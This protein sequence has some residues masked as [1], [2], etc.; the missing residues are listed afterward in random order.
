MIIQLEKLLL[1]LVRITSFIFLC[2]GFSFSGLP[3]TVKIALSFS[4]S[5]ILYM[6]LPEI[7]VISG[8]FHFVVLIIK[9]TLFGIAMGYITQ[10]VYGIMEIAGQL[11]DF[12]V[13]FS[14][15]S[16]YDPSM[17]TTASNYGKT[18]YWLS[19]SIFF[20][21]DMHHRVIETLIKSFEY[22]PIGTAGFQGLTVLSILNLFSRV[23]ELAVNLAAP[24][25]IVV[26][27]TD[28]VLGIISRTVPQINVLMLGMPLKSMVSFFITILM[29][30]WLMKTIG[31]GLYLIPEY[32]EKI[33]PLF[34]QI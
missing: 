20:L 7:G 25:I 32:M 12:Q 26:L 22:I 10:L 14:M 19:I 24:M 11:I 18:Y 6:I 17:G 2:P 29:L 4:I 8:L 9:E 13:G 1:I 23:F 34:R 33:I 30:S 15:A 27:V 28:V 5:I 16:V 3:N 21:L 31:N